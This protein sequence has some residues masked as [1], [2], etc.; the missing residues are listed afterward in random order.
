MTLKIVA[1][2]VVPVTAVPAAGELDVAAANCP[3]DRT[4]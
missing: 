2:R 3:A 1:V 4:R